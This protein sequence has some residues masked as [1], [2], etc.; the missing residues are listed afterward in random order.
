M[1]EFCIESNNIRLH[2]RLDL[3]RESQNCPLLIIIHGLTGYM[4]EDHLSALAEAANEIGYAVLRADL[5]GHGKSDGRFADHTVSIWLEEVLTVT[6]YAKSLSFVTELY[7]AGHSQGG[8]V[9][10]LAAGM[11]PQDYRALILLSPALNIPED[12]RQGVFLHDFR[13]DPEHI[14]ESFGFDGRRLNGSYLADAW[15][16]HS[17]DSLRKYDGPVLIIHGDQDEVIPLS[18]SREAAALCKNS[19]L[20]ILPGDDHDYHLHTGM[21]TE[22]VKQFLQETDILDSDS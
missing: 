16:I 22:A 5:Y 9:A 7:I 20:I 18:V 4:D 17:E 10:A 2:C 13:F 21:M 12:A 8:L 11:R 1:K 19:R 3:P 14:P 6:D 15:R